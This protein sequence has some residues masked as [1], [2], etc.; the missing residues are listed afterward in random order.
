MLFYVSNYDK[1]NNF[2]S[3]E[4]IIIMYDNQHKR[5]IIILQNNE[6]ELNPSN[7]IMSDAVIQIHCTCMHPHC[8]KKVVF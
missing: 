3:I 7:P 2:Y 5:R 6:Y 8:G 1:A 4:L